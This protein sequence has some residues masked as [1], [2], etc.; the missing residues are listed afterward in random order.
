MINKLT[1][2]ITKSLLQLRTKMANIKPPKAGNSNDK[3]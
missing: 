2:T 3:D 1:E